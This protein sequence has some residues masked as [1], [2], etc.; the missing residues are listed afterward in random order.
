[1][2]VTPAS[3]GL[4]AVRGATWE[5]TFTYNDP[6]GEPVDL[7]G[8]EARMQVRTLDGQ[9]GLTTTD[10]LVM[11]LTTENGRLSIDEPESG[12]VALRVEAEDMVALNPANEKKDVLAYSLELFIP[13]AGSTPEYVIPLVQ[14]KVTVLGETTR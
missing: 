10:T 2:S 3:A 11:E 7:T 14:G 12:V 13:A 4:K 5:D 1:M 6:D 8:Y 9:Y